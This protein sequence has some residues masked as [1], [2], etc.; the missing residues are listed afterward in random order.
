M[1][2]YLLPVEGKFY[3]ANLHMH[4]NI[5][6]GE[7]SVLETKEEYLKRG[8][9]IVA[10]TDH[11]VMVPHEDICDD[12]FLAITSTEILA[13]ERT[14]KDGSLRRTYHLNIYSPIPNKTE[15]NT[16]NE[17]V[18]WKKHSLEYIT[19]AQKTVKY[20][21]FYDV[22]SINDIIEKA[23]SEGCLVSYNHPVWSLQNYADYIGIKG[24]WGIEW[25]N[26]ACVRMG[27][28]DSMK[29]IDDLLRVGENVYPLATDDA[30]SVNDCFGGFVMVKAKKLD[31]NSVFT[32]LKNGDFYSSEKPEIYELSCENGFVKVKTSK[33]R[34]ITLTTN[35]RFTRFVDC[36]ENPL[37]EAYFDINWLLEKA[38]IEEDFNQYIRITVT[39]EEGNVAHTRAYFIKELM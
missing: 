3:K 17:D 12:N 27:Y 11:E 31:Y 7:M 37:T 24:L 34:K 23:N 32:A 33:A 22:N 10:F 13:N 21:R 8:Y 19:P 35:R 1:K 25:H 20:E 14:T 39:D 4:T 29:P 26:S 28:I 2:K 9:S 18:I 30:H 16:F 38:K 6:D 5:S 36:D 15:F